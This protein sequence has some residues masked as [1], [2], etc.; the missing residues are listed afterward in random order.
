MIVKKDHTIGRR[1]KNILGKKRIK[2]NLQYVNVQ[3]T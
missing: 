2:I 1:I 3:I